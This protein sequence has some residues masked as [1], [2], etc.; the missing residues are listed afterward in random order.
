MLYIIRAYFHEFEP[1]EV[2]YEESPL[3][4][5]GLVYVCCICKDSSF[6][7]NFTFKFRPAPDPAE[8]LTVPPN[9]HL[10]FSCVWQRIRAA[11]AH[12]LRPLV[13]GEP[14]SEILATDSMFQKMN[15]LHAIQELKCLSKEYNKNYNF[16]EESI[17][18][19]HN[20]SIR[21]LKS[22]NPRDYWNIIN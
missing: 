6:L 21:N 20:T 5:A 13:Q 19:L 11:G 15:Y 12:S 1:Q 22:N 16:K 14:P 7:I 10:V 3:L 2:G 8:G 18:K 4:C 9:T 17:H